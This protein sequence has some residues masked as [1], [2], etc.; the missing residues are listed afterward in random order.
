MTSPN[1]LCNWLRKSNQ[2]LGPIIISPK[3][4]LRRQV[5]KMMVGKAVGPDNILV[6]IWKS[7]GEEG[8]EW[9]TNFFNIIFESAKM[10]KNGD[11]IYSY[12]CIRIKGTPKAATTIGC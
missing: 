3:R 4:R 7:L 11:T 1:T 12:H 10:H 9:L 5:R 6:K 8:L 2:T